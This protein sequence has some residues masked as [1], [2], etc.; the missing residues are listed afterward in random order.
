MSSA[1][2]VPKALVLVPFVCPIC[3][4]PNAVNLIALSRAGG[5]DCGKC[6][7]RLR[8]ADVMRAMHSPR[9]QV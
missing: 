2:I 7:K 9:K 4:G 6:G 8:S 5:V 1:V 3:A